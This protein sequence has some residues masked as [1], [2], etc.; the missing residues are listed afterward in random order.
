MT[1]PLIPQSEA[2]NHPARL[3]DLLKN[4]DFRFLLSGQVVADL[5]DAMANLA[6]LLMVNYLTGSTRAIAGISIAMA[7]PRLVLGLV[8]GVYVD[9]FDRKKIMIAANLLRALIAPLFILALNPE[10]MWLMYV[11]AFIQASIGTFF[12]PARTALLPSI[13]PRHQL[14]SANSFSQ[15]GQTLFMLI[16]STAAGVLLSG[17]RYFWV[18][19]VVN[20]CTFL[21]AALL[22][23]RINDAYK[24]QQVSS[25]P[26]F[27]EIWDNLIAGLK[28]I[29]SSKVL[30][31]TLTANALTMLGV[32]AINVLLVPLLVNDLQMPS[33]WMGAVNL[34]ETAAMVI[35]GGVIVG[36]FAHIRPTTMLPIGLLGFGAFMG[37]TVFSSS[38]WYVMLIMFLSCLFIPPVSSSIQTIQQTYV[39]DD[40]RGRISASYSAL[41][42]TATLLSMAYAGVLAD[43]IGSRSVFLISGLLVMAAGVAAFMMFKGLGELNA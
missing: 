13:V 1:E 37:L 41:V 27:H 42:T 35:S 2:H 11:L 8:S 12:I 43:V 4:R 30:S 21:T 19:F 36:L 32:G 14:L 16:G 6:M 40:L 25:M 9:R 18:A 22:H 24:P 23:S 3:G 17:N 39:S 5:G 28:A 34:S 20:A 33:S 29:F 10:R 7:L 26:N 15:T 31:S 38:V